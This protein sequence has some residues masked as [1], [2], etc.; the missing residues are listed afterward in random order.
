MKIELLDIRGLVDIT[1]QMA[2][3][4]GHLGISLMLDRISAGLT[5]VIEG[6]YTKIV[7]PA[8]PRPRKDSDYE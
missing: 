4:D 1:N 8:E 7:E 5:D 6:R 2:K 3:A